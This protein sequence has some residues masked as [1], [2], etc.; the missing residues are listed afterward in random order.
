LIARR[1]F[2][3]CLTRGPEAGLAAEAEREHFMTVHIS[4]ATA[5]SVALLFAAACGSQPSEADRRVAELESKLE[6]TQKQLETQQLDS[7]KQAEAARQA[8]AA[9]P[10]PAPTSGTTP[11]AA[12]KK[13]ASAS[14]SASQS[15]ASAE[16]K[17]LV[18]AQKDVNAQQ[19]ALNEK[20]RDVNAQQADT[21]AKL[22]QQ[23]D[24][25]K[26]REYVLPAG[27]VIAVRPTAELSTEKLAN[28]SAFDVVLERDLTAGDTVI[29]KAGSRASGFV[30]T[31]DPGGR[32]K[33]VAS[34]TVG[35]RS[36]VGAKANVIAV[37]TDTY[38]VDA[39]S[40][41]KK[42]AVRTGIASGVG[43]AI[44]AIAGGGKG[45]AIG[46]G[47]GAAAGV[48]T[49]MATRGEAAVIPA[50]ELLEFKLTAPVTVTMQPSS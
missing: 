5:V 25:L 29:A 39:K 31:S 16:A 21:N 23:V 10:A 38:S 44:G 17:K 11:P 15:A 42:D 33:G 26:P 48:G 41:K 6:S 32:V 13:P 7:Q 49:N 46:A 22:Q 4:R 50:E 12:A 28:G 1:E 27:T 37:S 20:Q 24:Q 43:A 30:V 8:T 36:I 14:K 34:L 40:S 2:A 35:L 45:A 18:D 47:A 3:V 9:E 19:R